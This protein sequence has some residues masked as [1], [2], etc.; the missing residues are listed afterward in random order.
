M[1]KTIGSIFDPPPP[2]T[3]SWWPREE[4]VALDKLLGGGR[5]LGHG[6]QGDPSGQLKPPI[7]LDPPSCLGSGALAARTPP[8]PLKTVG[9]NQPDG[10]PC[11]GGEMR[12]LHELVCS[13]GPPTKR[14]SFFPFPCSHEQRPRTRCRSG[15]I[16]LILILI[17]T[18][19]L[20]PI[21]RPGS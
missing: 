1:G 2:P 3:R 7:D 12:N 18:S 11:K 4:A 6:L 8:K 13:N 14:T 10:S 16:K 21:S 20:V 19:T 15:E 17:S 9:F 5:G